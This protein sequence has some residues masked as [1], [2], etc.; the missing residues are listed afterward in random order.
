MLLFS[1]DIVFLQK[2][3]QSKSEREAIVILAGL[4]SLKFNE[5][6]IAKHFR[7]QG[8][9]IYQP[10]YI[11]RKNIRKGVD[12][13]EQFSAQHNLK[14]YKKVH[15][16][17]YI[18]G[19]WT[20]N[21]WYSP[22]KL[23]NVASI[24]YDRSPLQERA[25]FALVKD[26]KFLIEFLVGKVIT[27]LAFAHY[28]PLKNFQGK[29]GILIETNPSKLILKHKVSAAS[30]GPLDWSVEALNQNCS[31]FCYAPVNHDEM[32]TNIEK[33]SPQVWSFIK[34]GA[35]G[36]NANRVIPTNNPLID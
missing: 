19:A 15:F 25:P 12:K 22:D 16:F 29:V 3:V 7:N 33:V 21:T 13:L 31:D 28:V 4:G 2:S 1:R 5:R 32:Y 10:A 34:T 36:E 14:A 18:I 9:D 8:Y 6:K 17:C 20:F 35:F 24:I 27:E 11:Y 23:N 30:L 26:K